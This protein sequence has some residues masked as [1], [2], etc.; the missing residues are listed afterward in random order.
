MSRE[1]PFEEDAICEECGD[2]GAYDFMGDYYCAMCLKE[3]IE[4]YEENLEDELD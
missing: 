3:A 4:D 2:R 1:I